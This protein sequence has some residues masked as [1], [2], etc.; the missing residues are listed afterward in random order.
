MPDSMFSIGP[1]HDWK[2]A[3]FENSATAQVG[4]GGSR[5]GAASSSDRCWADENDGN[6]AKWANFAKCF[7]IKKTNPLKKLNCKLKIEKCSLS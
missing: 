6:C 5:Q 4:L 2:S 7:P 1:K 3:F